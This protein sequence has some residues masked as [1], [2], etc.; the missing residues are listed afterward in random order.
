[1]SNRPHKRPNRDRLVFEIL[2]LARLLLEFFED[3]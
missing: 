1:M 2:R 3:H